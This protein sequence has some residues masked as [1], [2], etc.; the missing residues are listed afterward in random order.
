MAPDIP[1]KHRAAMFKEKG[2]PL[3]IEEVETKMPGPGQVLLKVLAAGCCHS[4]TYVQGE[5]LGIKL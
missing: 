2:G 1:K 3:V 5:E 4:D